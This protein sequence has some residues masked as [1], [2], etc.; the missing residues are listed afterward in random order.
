MNRNLGEKNNSSKLINT[1]F[2]CFVGS[3][4][5]CFFDDPRDDTWSSCRSTTGLH[6]LVVQ[7]LDVD[8]SCWWVP[9]WSIKSGY[10]AQKWME[11][12]KE[13]TKSEEKNKKWCTCLW[14]LKATCLS[15]V[16]QHSLPWMF[17]ICVCPNVKKNYVGLAH[18]YTC[19]NLEGK[20]YHARMIHIYLY[21]FIYIYI[22]F[23][24]P[25]LPNNL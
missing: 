21:L 3:I 12:G 24:C 7:C 1:F 20:M 25:C 18:E 11:L 23:I 22:I 19:K 8:M 13:K 16:L 6:G 15:G 5:S 2:F 17:S 4:P 10:P 14:T 9:I